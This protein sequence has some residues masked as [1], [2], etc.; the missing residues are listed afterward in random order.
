[1]PWSPALV[2]RVESALAR[3]GVRG[4]RQKHVFG[5]RGFLLGKRAAVI[6]W[7]D[8]LL[9]KVPAAEYATALATPGVT[10]FAP[11]GARPMTTW[12]V[13]AEEAIAD[14]PELAAWVARGVAAVR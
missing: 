7:D 4:A 2:E 9:V 6:V 11:D 13:V 8:A 5:G 10:P 14:D 3:L 1:M 12:V